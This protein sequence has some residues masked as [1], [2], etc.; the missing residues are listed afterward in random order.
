[1]DDIGATEVIKYMKGRSRLWLSPK[2]PLKNLREGMVLKL[3]V[4]VSQV[5][6]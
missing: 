3:N 4:S 1:M 5:R 2:I 6:D